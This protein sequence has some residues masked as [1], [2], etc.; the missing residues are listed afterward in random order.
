MEQE[1]V[2]RV[3]D[4]MR[5]REQQELHALYDC[6]E[7]PDMVECFI[8]PQIERMQMLADKAAK[9]DNR[10]FLIALLDELANT[11]DITTDAV[12]YLGTREQSNYEF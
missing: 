8:T 11:L 6:F 7:A 2:V 9:A 10:E 3:K 12:M 1:Y 4:V 5:K